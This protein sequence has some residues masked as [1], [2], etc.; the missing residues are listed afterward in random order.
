MTAE[1]FQHGFLPPRRNRRANSVSILVVL[2]RRSRTSDSNRDGMVAPLETSTAEATETDS[3][4]PVF[5]PHPLT[6]RLLASSPGQHGT[7]Q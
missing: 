4:S 7:T 1:L 2:L 5:A 6:V 3:A